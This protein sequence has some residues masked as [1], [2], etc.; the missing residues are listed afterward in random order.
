[1]PTLKQY[2]NALAN[3]GNMG[4]YRTITTTSASA[5]G[6]Q[7]VCST[8]G[9][10]TEVGRSGQYAKTWVMLTETD[11]SITAGTVRQV[12]SN[13][14]EVSTGTLSLNASL[15]STPQTAKVWEMYFRLP[16]MESTGPDRG[17]RE[18]INDALADMWIED[19]IDISGVT[20]QV[21]YTLTLTTNYW[22]RDKGRIG[23][24]RKPRPAAT[25]PWDMATHQWT[26]HEDGQNM[27][28]HLPSAPYVTGDTFSLKVYRPANSLLNLTGSFAE[29]SSPTV[30]L[31]SL[32]HEAVP[33][34]ND[35]STVALYFAYLEMAK[36]APATEADFW[37]RAADKQRVRSGLLMFSKQPP[38]SIGHTE[39][40]SVRFSGSGVSYFR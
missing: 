5:Q 23:G 1:M 37:L 19:Y 2:I 26:V 31:T 28:L 36:G 24:I 18:C 13:G 29:Q 17:L 33:S 7:I 8:I 9:N 3:S 32:T 25:D 12:N 22:L 35:V 4:G 11:G 40:Q 10:T 20:N 14:F 15:A 16:P 21:D 34:V 38:G 27:I 6:N 39:N 30:G